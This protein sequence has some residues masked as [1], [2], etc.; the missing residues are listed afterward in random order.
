M[1]SAPGIVV[2]Q[3]RQPASLSI[4]AIFA[5]KQWRTYFGALANHYSTLLAETARDIR[6]AEDVAGVTYLIDADVVRNLVEARYKDSR[7]RRE[8]VRLFQSSNFNY[9]LPLGAFQEII[10]WLRTFVPNRLLWSDNFLSL[11]NLSREET[12]LELAEAFDVP[13]GNAQPSQLIDRIFSRL[14]TNRLI[15][16]R[17]IDLFSRPNFKG[18]AADYELVDVAQLHP[19]LG[20]L[21]RSVDDKP[22]PRV[23]RDYRDAINVAIVCKNNRSRSDHEAASPGADCPRFIL[24]TQTHILLDLVGRV[25][26]IDDESLHTLSALLGL[27]GPVLGGL[28]PVISPRRAFVV[29][30]VRRRYG[31][32]TSALDELYQERRLYDDLVEI[33]GQ[34]TPRLKASVSLPPNLAARLKHLVEVYYG[35]DPFYRRLEQDRAVDASLRYLEGKFKVEAVPGERRVAALKSEAESF[36]KVLHKLHVLTDQL[37]ATSYEI[38]RQLDESEAFEVT[39][40]SSKRPDEILMD[41]EIYLKKS[42]AG[43]SA[44]AGYSFRWP[45][46]STEDQFLEALSSIIRLAKSDRRSPAEIRFE[47][48]SPFAAPREGVIVF[49]DQGAFRSC[50]A[51]IPHQFKTLSLRELQ[52]L[53]QAADGDAQRPLLIEAIRISTSFAEF[54]L[55]ITADSS[56]NRDVFVLSGY[57]IGEQISHLCQATSLLPVLPIKLNLAL[58][59]IT[60]ALPRHERSA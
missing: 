13:V 59:E 23:K 29:E 25:N 45:T 6:L 40:I 9:A 55:D 17:L 58:Q 42:A 19:L 41:G 35:A 46:S 27:P 44:P 28:Y 36:F 15:V 37:A 33:L 5:E 60:A 32:E 14:G 22:E 30:E 31:F 1:A 7:L 57:N 53:V 20:L 43:S 21:Q 11:G 18:V 16:E 52:K 26:D 34:I 50:S 8:S 2:L 56:G 12:V 10:E 24:V 48:M 4:E 3:D 51:E 38:T 39:Q 54:Q 47:P 49:T